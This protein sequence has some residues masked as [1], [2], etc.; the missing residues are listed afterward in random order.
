MSDIRKLEKFRLMGCE[1]IYKKPE[2][3]EEET[4]KEFNIF[5]GF[6][7][8]PFQEVVNKTKAKTKPIIPLKYSFIN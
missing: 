4:K 5:K 7:E 2:W 3:V 6:N 1:V 8:K